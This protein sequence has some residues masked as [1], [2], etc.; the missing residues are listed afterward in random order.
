MGFNQT[1]LALVISVFASALVLAGVKVSLRYATIMSIVEMLALIILSI[2]FLYDSGFRFYNP[3]NLNDISP[4]LLYAVILGLGIP[5]GYGSIAPLSEEAED[6]LAIGKAV[7]LVLLVGGALASF[8]FYSL[9]ALGFTG[10]LV[11]YLLSRFGLISL[12]SLSFIAISD[13][14]LGGMTYILANSRT[15]KAM[16]ADNIFPTLFTKEYKGRPLVAEAFIAAIFVVV[17][18]AMTHFIGLYNTFVTLGSIAGL[19]NVFIHSSTNFSLLRI[20]SRRALKHIPEIIVAVIALLVSIA[21]FIYS[22]PSINKYIQDI[23]FG[24]II[25]GFLYAEALDIIREDQMEKEK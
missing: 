14:T 23:F 4:T 19:T 22:L 12:I 25:F 13:G 3:F 9:G 2:M 5:T 17:L 18:T 10:N 20:S 8:F 24:W 15:F 16:S 1:I 6:K 11:D 21:V 7:I